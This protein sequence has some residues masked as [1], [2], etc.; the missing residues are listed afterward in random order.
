MIIIIIT[1]IVIVINHY[2]HC[3]YHYYIYI[4]SICIYTMYNGLEVHTTPSIANN[5]AISALCRQ[6]SPLIHLTFAPPR[7]APRERSG[8]SWQTCRAGLE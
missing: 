6:N 5:R 2:Y 1:I 4:Y 3:H 8:S 7:T